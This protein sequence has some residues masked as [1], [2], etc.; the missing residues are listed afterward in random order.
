M[1]GNG[2][3]KKI[4]WVDWSKIMADKKIGV[5][6]VG[7]LLAQNI[8]LLIK[9]WWRL[10]NEHGNWVE[11][12]ESIHNLKAHP[13]TFLCR[14]SNSGVWGNIVKAIK[15]LPTYNIDTNGIFSLIPSFN[16]RI[17]ILF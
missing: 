2:D 13:S 10:S 3:K 11:V 16:I 4:H 9:W 15:S 6:E 8:A 17:R 5:L 12:V 1:G 7:T 14:K